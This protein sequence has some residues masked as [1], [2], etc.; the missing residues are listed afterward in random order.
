MIWS[1][2][3][4]TKKDILIG[5]AAG[6]ISSILLGPFS[7]LAGA[8]AILVSYIKKSVT[9]MI[10]AIT[11]LLMGIAYVASTVLIEFMPSPMLFMGLPVPQE[12]IK[13]T[14][15]KSTSSI[16]TGVQV[17]DTL[18]SKLFTGEVWFSKDDSQYEGYDGSNVVILG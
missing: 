2:V 11:M 8:I 14:I 4:F 13:N 12:I 1:A 10:L 9:G 15:I 16:A 5:A 7:L 17:V 6:G 3:P 18:P